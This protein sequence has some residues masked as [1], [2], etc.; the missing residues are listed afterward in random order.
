VSDEE[1]VALLT[2]AGYELESVIAAVLAGDL[3]L[4]RR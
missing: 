1:T 2:A 3:T 4:L